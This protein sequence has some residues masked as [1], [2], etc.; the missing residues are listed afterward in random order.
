VLSRRPEQV[1]TESRAAAPSQA[2]AERGP[3]C[4]VWQLLGRADV[5]V[6][7]VLEAQDRAERRLWEGR[8]RVWL[9]DAARAWLDTC[10]RSW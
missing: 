4:E 10:R 1:V 2:S 7:A 5:I 9:Q 6:R 3:E 8:A